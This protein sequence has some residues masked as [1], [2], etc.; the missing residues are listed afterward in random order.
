[1]ISAPCA[2]K[3]NTVALWLARLGMAAIF[4]AQLKPKP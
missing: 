3:R 2:G 4:R 1:M